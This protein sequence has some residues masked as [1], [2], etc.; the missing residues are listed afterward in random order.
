MVPDNSGG[1]GRN[2]GSPAHEN[3]AVADKG[4]REVGVFSIAPDPSLMSLFGP[5]YNQ[6]CPL[7]WFH[8]VQLR[9]DEY[10]DHL[11][12]SRVNDHLGSVVRLPNPGCPWKL[13][14]D[15]GVPVRSPNCWRQGVREVHV[16]GCGPLSD[17]DCFLVRHSLRSGKRFFLRIMLSAHPL[18]E[19][20]PVSTVAA[21]TTAYD[22]GGPDQ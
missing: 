13:K 22:H 16:P 1:N 14:G 3:T 11:T 21:L 10:T 6:E 9:A 19:C 17:R 7:V 2:P 15:Y 12:G 20:N 4:G 8:F 5:P 18:A